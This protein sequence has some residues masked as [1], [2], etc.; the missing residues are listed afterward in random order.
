MKVRLQTRQRGKRRL[1]A[2]TVAGVTAA[3]FMTAIAPAALATTTAPTGLPQAISQQTIAWGPCS[4]YPGTSSRVQCATITAPLDWDNPGSGQTVSLALSRVLASDQAHRKGI[5]LVNP[6]GPGCEAITLPVEIAGAQPAVGAD[7]DVVTM[8]PRGV[9]FSTNYNCDIPN[10]V[11]AAANAPAYDTRDQSAA[12]VASRQAYAKAIA[13]ACAQN[14]LTPYINTW[15]TVHDMDLIRQL[16]GEAKLNYLGYSYGSWFGAK[17]A[18]VFPDTTGKVVLDSNT[19]WM[20]D[21]ANTWE[22][23]S[24]PSAS[25]DPRRPQRA[26]PGAAA[27]LRTGAPCLRALAKRLLTCCFTDLHSPEARESGVKQR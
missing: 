20:D 13:D 9:G 15:Q 8:D 24:S 17:Y 1:V 6:G 5:L 10:S 11:L 19:A 12:A 18:A 27:R 21:L 16:L 23:T 2:A 26:R 7:Y 4:W 14:P 25:A 22:V 3:G